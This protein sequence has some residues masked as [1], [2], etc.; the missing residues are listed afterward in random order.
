MADVARKSRLIIGAF[1]YFINEGAS[2][3]SVTVAG[4]AKPDNSPTSNWLS[5]GAIEEVK[6]DDVRS[7]EK[8]ITPSEAG[9]YYEEQEDYITGDFIN[10][11]TSHMNELVERLQFGLNSVIVAGTAQE[12]H[13]AHTRQ[14]NGWL[15]IQGRKLSG[16]DE[17]IMDWWAKLTLADKLTMNDKTLRP[18]LRFQKLTSTLNTV[19]FPA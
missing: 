1:A 3:D 5:L 15:K 8:F 4:T 9:G 16:S 7:S 13:A 2:I 12:P 6:F 19:V 14:V 11:R 18:V 10:L 17:F